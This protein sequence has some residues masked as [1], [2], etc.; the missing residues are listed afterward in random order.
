[1]S[2]RR[3]VVRSVA[4][5]AVVGISASLLG[6]TASS[7]RATPRAKLP[8]GLR[9]TEVNVT[10]D[11]KNRYGEPEI[12]VNPKNENNLVYA[13]LTIGTTYAC[14]KA[15]RPECTE[16]NTAFG[17]QPK[18]LI[19]DVPGFSHVRVYVSFDRGKTWK[20]SKDV[21]AYPSGKKDL[22]ERGDPLLTA[23]P[24]GTFYLAWDDIHFANLP[25]TIIRDAGI[26]VSTSKDGGRTWS[27]PVLTGTPVD[28]PFF[29]TDLST[30]VVYEASTSQLGANSKGD[31]SIPPSPIGGPGGDRW[32]VSSRDGVHWTD[33]KGFG[34]VVSFP[35]STYVAAAHGMFATAFAPTDPALCGGAASCTIFQTTT[36]SGA[37]WSRHVLPPDVSG[38]PLVAAD[39]TAAGHFSIAVLNPT[40][41]QFLVYQTKDAGVTWSGPTMVAEDATKTHFHPWMAYSPKGVLGLM[42]QTNFNSAP[43]TQ[44][45]ALPAALPESILAT[46]SEQ[47]REAI[48]SGTKLPESVLATLPEQVREAIAAQAAGPLSPYN[49]WAAISDDGGATF[50]APLQVS[51]GNSPAPQEFLPFGI[52]DDFSFLALSGTHAFV[53]WADYRPGDRQGFFSAIKLDAF[54]KSS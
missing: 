36:D 13:V 28:R 4:L 51:R 39:P 20:Q 40:K 3:R 42:W 49:V 48:E 46:L 26:A 15:K 23:G 19:E 6:V 5:V 32:L 8:R 37:T 18:G 21:P 16:L 29:A 10:K 54:R 22:V 30:G 2:F 53:A 45:G 11:P 1:M 17:P 7:G 24:D 41:T 14:Q 38:A 35:P 12:A 43:A 34:G 27:D 47:V 9:P 33:P 44:G 31:P 52:G 25:T 50:T